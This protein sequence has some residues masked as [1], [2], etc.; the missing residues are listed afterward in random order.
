MWKYA[1]KR[2]LMLIPVLVGVALIIFS[3][4]YITPGD[5]ARLVLGEQVSEEAI[6]AFRDKQ[7]LNDP[8]LVQFTN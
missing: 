3:L 2:M 5:P 4:L 6:K 8:F 1:L 7:G